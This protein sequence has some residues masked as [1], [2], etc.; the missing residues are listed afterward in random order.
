MQTVDAGGVV[1]RGLSQRVNVLAPGRGSDVKEKERR[2]APGED[3]VQM[4]IPIG[5]NPRSLNTEVTNTSLTRHFNDI[6]HTFISTNSILY[7]TTCIMYKCTCTCTMCLC[8]N[9]LVYILY[10]SIFTKNA[11][12]CK[13]LPYKRLVLRASRIFHE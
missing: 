5:R 2:K 6:L 9:T 8:V 3:G 7:T 10:S 12:V 11:E 4:V 13:H 1:M